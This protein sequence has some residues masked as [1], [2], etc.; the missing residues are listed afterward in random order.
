MFADTAEIEIQ[1]GAGGNGC[2]S[3]RREKYVAK[4]GPDGG[5]GGRGGHVIFVGSD[6]QNTLAIFRTEKHWHAESGQA[7]H[8]QRKNGRN[9]EDLR[10]PVPL[11]TM[12]FKKGAD[13]EQ[14]LLADIVEKNQEFVAATGGR[15]GFGN[16]HFKSSVRQTPDFAELGEPTTPQNLWLEIKLVADIGIIGLPSAGKSTFLS[17]VSAA[18]P[19]IAD[20]DFTTLVPNLGVASWHEHSLVLCDVPGLIAGASAGR[21]LGHQFLRH[22]ER[23]GALLHLVDSTRPD[24]VENYRQIRQ[25][26][27]NY[28]A[29]LTDKQEIVAL[30]KTD[31]AT[32]A[33]EQK[34]ALEKASGQTVFLLSAATGQGT[35]EILAK[36]VEAAA[37]NRAERVALQT[38]REQAASDNSEHQLYQPH[39]QNDK[40]SWKIEKLP[41]FWQ[42]S[43][44]RLEQLALMTNWDQ[45]GGW[46]RFLDILRKQKV[47]AR[48][49]NLGW[50]KTERVCVGQ[51][52]I[53]ALLAEN[54]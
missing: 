11:G 51:V 6:S 20:Y 36:L 41:R 3:M 14:V 49:Q 45:R 15:G 29:A 25:E 43:G 1:A 21:G 16:A 37:H 40:N 48:L 32:D 46:E 52:E 38:E 9:G 33:D 44:K 27:R 8:K 42:I 22:I 31:A 47:L 24:V 12:I 28:G 10:I 17:C 7:G 19:K 2:V 4:G 5:N 54:A 13:G 53:T 50:Q 34:A 18:R 30:S 23:C 26:L 39:L 35:D